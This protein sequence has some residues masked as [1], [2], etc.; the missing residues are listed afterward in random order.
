[1]SKKT[2]RGSIFF[3]VQRVRWTDPWV[4]WPPLPQFGQCGWVPPSWKSMWPHNGILFSR[5]WNRKFDIC[6]KMDKPWKHYAYIFL[7]SNNQ[8][9]WEA[10]LTSIDTFR[11]GRDA[12]GMHSGVS[13]EVSGRRWD[14][15]SLTLYEMMMEDNTIRSAWRLLKG[16]VLC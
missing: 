12:A 7:T 5:A 10:C 14:P 16:Q 15:A 2:H 11:V 8:G 3:M 6:Y 1:M 9:R 4:G 13:R